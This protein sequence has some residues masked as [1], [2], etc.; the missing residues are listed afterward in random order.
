MDAG[1]LAASALF[2]G[3]TA[4]GAVVGVRE[5][6]PGEPFGWRAPGRVST[7]LAV[8]SG[9]GTSAPW[10]M[11]VAAVV[12]ALAARPGSTLPAHACLGLGSACLAGTFVEP[13]TWGWR[14]TSAAAALTVVLNLLSGAALVLAGRRSVVTARRSSS[15]AR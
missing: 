10:P 9:C 1:M 4:Y 11:P 5:D 2:A 14:S 13:N 8:G 3:A 7:Q 15:A 12:A 6:I